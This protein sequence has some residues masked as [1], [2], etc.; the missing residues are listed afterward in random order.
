M[1]PKLVT[2]MADWLK[3]PV[4]KPK[5][6][7]QYSGWLSLSSNQH[8]SKCSILIFFQLRQNRL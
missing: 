3:A 8:Y 5:T 4:L 1:H 7:I 2:A 6:W